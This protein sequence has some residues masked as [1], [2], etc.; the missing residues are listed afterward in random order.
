MEYGDGEGSYSSGGRIFLRVGCKLSSQSKVDGSHT[1]E[2]WVRAPHGRK[3]MSHGA[4][5][6]FHALFVDW[7]VVCVKDACAEFVSD[8]L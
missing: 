5:V 7:L 8:D 6:L 4:E 2:S 3:D 1:V